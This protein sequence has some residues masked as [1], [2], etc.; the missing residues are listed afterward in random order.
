MTMWDQQFAG[1]AFKYGT[2]PNAFLRREAGR[3]P[4]VAR[5]LVPGD[6]E[7]RNGVWLATQ[8]HR[9]VAMDS[10]TVGLR[11]AARL[12]AERGV[13][14]ETVHGDLANWVPEAGSF[15]AVVLT[16]VHLP[17]DLR[18]D[19]HRRLA[20]A[21]KAGGLLLLEGFHPL[22]LGC[23]SGGPKQVEWLYR[24]EDLRRDFQGVLAEVSSEESA[25]TL[26]EGPGHQGPAWVTRYIGRRI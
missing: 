15:D 14:I 26:D 13:D 25:I 17:P 1:E 8:G 9:V 20:G 5:V 19:A 11:K 21:L 12:A 23:S 3:L 24:L 18:P 10:S 2:E 22:Q 4:T 7:G 16:Y 6:G